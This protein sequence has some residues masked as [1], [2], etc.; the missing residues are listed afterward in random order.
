M[1]MIEVKKPILQT[2]ALANDAMLHP[3]KGT[4]KLVMNGVS[5]ATLTLADK[6][7]TIPMH[8]FVK[9]FNQLGF[10]GYFR[11]T[12]RGQNIGTENTYTLRHGIDILQDSVWDAEETFTG[13]KAQLMAAILN[14]QTQLI[15]GVK[16]WA[17]GSCADT[18]SITKDI[19]YDNLLDL[20]E[21]LAEDGSGYYFTYNQSVWPWQ[22]SLVAKPNTVAS[23]FRLD[24]N[25][26]KC[27]IKDNDSELC[28]RLILSVNKM[29]KDDT[30]SGETADGSEVTQNETV[31][32]TYNNTSAQSSYGIIVKTADIDVTQDTFPN[33]PFP[34]AD[35]WAADFLARRASPLLEITID[36][37]V[38]NGITGS[39]WDD[40]K[41]GTQVRVALPDYPGA[42][43]SERCVSVTYSDLYGQPDHVSVNLA[44]SLPTFSQSM[45]STQKTVS[46]N[47][48][49]S[50][51]SSRQ[52]KSFEQN[53]KITNTAGDVLR[54]A[55][56][57]LDANG[58][59]VYADDNVNMVGSR[60]DVQADKIGMV[61]GTNS[62]GNYIK[63]GEITLAINNAG[64]SEAHIDAN[65]VYIGNEKSTT[66]INGKCSLSDVT[67]TYIGGKIA[68]LTT[69]TV[70]SIAASGTISAGR[71]NGDS[72]YFRNSAGAGYTYSN[73]KAEAMSSLTLV[74]NGND[75]YTLKSY[76]IDGTETVVGTFNRGGGGSDRIAGWNDYESTSWKV[77][78]DADSGGK[79]KVPSQKDANGNWSYVEWGRAFNSV[80]WSVYS[81][82]E[83]QTSQPQG[84]TNAGTV[85]TLSSN[86][87]IKFRLKANGDTKGYYI[88]VRV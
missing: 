55:G 3:V 67:A 17:L 43:V 52:A 88:Y 13:T 16:P 70:Q 22:V 10:V 32:R 4:L 40:S 73:V 79:F 49:S 19:N 74:D 82:P 63:A 47:S 39:D 81:S 37:E 84:Y 35:A 34:E 30:L 42:T 36:G 33:G 41:I 59:L 38:L 27:Q 5:E 25:I 7:E 71:L 51:S 77:P 57:K 53:F 48:R 87:Y 68:D 58:L 66:V 44:N 54:Q 14:K 9:I 76:K 1:A 46:S 28:T 6:A 29:V 69:V 72:I 8:R 18:S 65:K 60:F 83:V 75:T 78:T 62:Q 15:N 64:E 86:F 50:R 2:A 56:L 24:R 11:R 12:S 23:E 31:V 26:E 20:L 61:V 45:K 21:D 85:G 80:L